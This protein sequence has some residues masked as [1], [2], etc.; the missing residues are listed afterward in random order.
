MDP[1]AERRLFALGAD[2]GRIA[3]VSA[4]SHTPRMSKPM[5]WPPIND[6]AYVERLIPALQASIAELSRDRQ[7]AVGD[8]SLDGPDV[9]NT[10]LMLLASV[11]EPSPACR[12]PMGMRQV[13]EAAS[14]ELL[15]LMRDTRRLRLTETIDGGVH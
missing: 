15:A 12:T 10:L 4:P 9:A 3:A 11:L 5:P 6:D 8:V 7:D 2:R 14:K 1:Q 13:S